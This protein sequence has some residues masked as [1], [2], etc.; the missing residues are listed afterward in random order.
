MSRQYVKDLRVSDREE[1]D[2]IKAEVS[3][4]EKLLWPVDRYARNMERVTD[5]ARIEAEMAKHE[6]ARDEFGEIVESTVPLSDQWQKLM[7]QKHADFAG[8]SGGLCAG[9][10][11]GAGAQVGVVAGDWCRLTVRRC[12]RRCRCIRSGTRAI[13]LINSFEVPDEWAHWWGV[14]FGFDHPFVWG[15]FV[16]SP[17]GVLYLTQ[18]IHRTRTI[19]E[20]HARE[21]VSL[22][23]GQRMPQAMVCDHDPYG[24]ATLVRHMSE[25]TGGA[26]GGLRVVSAYKDVADG[27]AAVRARL[28][29]GRLFVF[30]DAVKRPD[31]LLLGSAE[32][33]VD[34][35]G[36]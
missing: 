5:I 7:D 22:T 28:R 13:H 3:E 16:E 27:I 30:R 21:I 12:R 11:A 1:I 6:S 20:D 9:A 10:V 24:Q 36:V 15:N 18:D 26:L 29:A 4:R 31:P 34:G 19:E 8:D 33:C 14:D 2:A 25:M 35:G 23:A 17:R 32:A